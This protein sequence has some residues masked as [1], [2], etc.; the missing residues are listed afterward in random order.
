MSVT[1][2]PPPRGPVQEPEERAYSKDYWDGVFEQI[3][4][5]RLVKLALSVLALLYGAAIYAPLIASDRPLYLEAIDAREYSQAQ[6]TISNAVTGFARLLAEGEESFL[7]NL[8]ASATTRTF[9]AALEA[10][11]SAV[12]QRIV[13]LE[14]FLGDADRTHLEEV[15]REL[16][17]FE[18]LVA[19]GAPKEEIAAAQSALRT[20]GR[21]LRERLAPADPE[22]PEA[23][24]VT[25]QPKRSWPLLEAL[26]G[27]EVFF[28]VLW[29]LLASWPVWNRLANRFVLGADRARIR[30]ARRPKAFLVLGLSAL[31]GLAWSGTVGGQMVFDASPFKARLTSGEM[32]ATKVVMPPIAMGL[33]ETH[34]N[35]RF[36]PP[37]WLESAQIDEQGYYLHGARA[38][39]PDP[40]TGQVPP[41]TPVEVRFG[42]PER[43]AT[44]RYMLG[45]DGL[46]RDLVTRL[47]HGA[48]IS[49]MVGLVSTL[50]L[51]T[52]GIVMGSLAGYLGGWVDIVISRT[53][54]IFQ[55]VPSFF[56]IL[57][58]VSVIDDDK[59]HP[60]LAIIV[61]IGLVSWTG[62]ARLVRGEFLK[63]KELEY[64]VAA[65]ALGFSTARVVFRHV[66]PNAMGPV[67][68]AASFSVA[69]GILIES[70]ISFLGLG[71]KLPIPS[72]GS[73]LNE[74]RSADFWWT[75]VFPG[76]FIFLTVFCYN[77]VGEGLR[78][79]L[80]PRMK[81]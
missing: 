50:L 79:A 75:Q 34:V 67:L 62:V 46:G 13:V 72:W 38:P 30:R 36:R 1:A 14:G 35:E 22:K 43:N 24:G 58:V 60:I 26:T 70:A 39:R 29:A 51:V 28:M 23:G 65:R 2:S 31:S 15:E 54:E 9:A 10:E 41:P 59:L 76:L 57:V 32:V 12:R 8:S 74:A 19:R 53:I 11:R 71:I 63:L 17:A 48:R 20:H 64:V 44:T 7:A 55:S 49:L 4:K 78:D 25:L 21:E 3:G 40:V 73:I 66:L 5:R 61:V 42:E 77:L 81:T 47:L 80:D 33:A 45:A 37:T 18:A 56:L 6:R 52:I 16:D 27:V 68:V 69:A